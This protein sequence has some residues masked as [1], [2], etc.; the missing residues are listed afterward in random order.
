MAFRLFVSICF[1]CHFA[2][3]LCCVQF[4]CSWVFGLFCFLWTVSFVD[5]NRH[6]S[7][8]EKKNLQFDVYTSTRG[9]HLLRSNVMVLMFALWT[10]TGLAFKW[11]GRH[12]TETFPLR[13]YKPYINVQMR[14]T[15]PRNCRRFWSH[16]YRFKFMRLICHRKLLPVT[17]CVHCDWCD[18]FWLA[19]SNAIDTWAWW[20]L[21]IIQ[22]RIWCQRYYMPSTNGTVA[23]CPLVVPRENEAGFCHAPDTKEIGRSMR[24]TFMYL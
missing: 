11:I 10:S 5:I 4:T 14:L 2:S 22:Q 21:I 9:G 1:L 6:T 17:V 19:S 13:I 18:Q 20:D 24:W 16:Q 23:Q 12:S 8:L 3:V 15:L 7:A